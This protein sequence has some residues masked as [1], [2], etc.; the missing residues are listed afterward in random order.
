[1][2]IDHNATTGVMGC[3]YHWNHIFGDINTQFQ[4]AGIKRRKMFSNKAFILMGNIQPDMPNTQALNFIVDCA[5]DNIAWCKFGAL[6]KTQHNASDN[7]HKQIT[8]FASN[9]GSD[10]EGA[11]T[12]R[13]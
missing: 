12:W 5:C 4:Q 8:H 2:F 6:V 11:S 7:G 13:M 1:M 10:R 3:R 9:G